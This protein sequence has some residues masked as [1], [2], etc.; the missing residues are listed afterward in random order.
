MLYKFLYYLIIK[1]TMYKFP[2]NGQ[3]I[4]TKEKR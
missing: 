1:V 4:K 3:I 2:S